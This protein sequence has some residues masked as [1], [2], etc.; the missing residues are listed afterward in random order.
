MNKVIKTSILRLTARPKISEKLDMSA[1]DAE[2]KYENVRTGYGRYLKKAKTIPSG[3]GGDVIP[4]PKDFAGLEWLQK[5]I[6]HRPT[7]S[8]MNPVEVDRDEDDNSSVNK[9]RQ[10]KKQNSRNSGDHMETP[11]RYHRSK[12]K[13]CVKHV[14]LRQQRQ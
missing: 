10:T 12:Q 5:Y 7:V 4:T 3:S 1:A 11:Y 14:F 6:S 2:K 9:A 13:F 8:N